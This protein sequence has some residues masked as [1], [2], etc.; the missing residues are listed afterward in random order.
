MLANSPP[1]S[2]VTPQTTKKRGA[3]ILRTCWALVSSV[4]PSRTAVHWTVGFTEYAQPYRYFIIF[5]GARSKQRLT[6]IGERGADGSCRPTK[7]TAYLWE[8]CAQTNGIFLRYG[9]ASKSRTP[10]YSVCK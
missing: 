6:E 10:K 8:T 1:W 5:P 7:Y 2:P 9:M 4:V 3:A